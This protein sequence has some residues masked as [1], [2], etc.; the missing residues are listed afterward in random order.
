MA[1]NSLGN[2]FSGLSSKGL[3][4][5]YPNPFNQL[6]KSVSANLSSADAGALFDH[7][8]GVEQGF[9][10]RGWEVVSFP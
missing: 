1:V 4:P 5:S 10:D 6:S 8:D 3:V 7:L 2:G 9:I